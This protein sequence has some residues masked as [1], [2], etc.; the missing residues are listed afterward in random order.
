MWVN[1]QT[2]NHAILQL[3][4]AILSCVCSCKY[5]IGPFNLTFLTPDFSFQM[6]RENSVKENLTPSTNSTLVQFTIVSITGGYSL[7]VK[8]IKKTSNTDLRKSINPPMRDIQEQTNGRPGIQPSENQRF[9]KFH[10][11]VPNST[12]TIIIINGKS[13]IKQG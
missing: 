11:H 1:Y 6:E 5:I 8:H 4:Q 3:L 2:T 7:H 10:C 12:V 9:I 13:G